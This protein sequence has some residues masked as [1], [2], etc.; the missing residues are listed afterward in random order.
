MLHKLVADIIRKHPLSNSS[1]KR[2]INEMVENIEESLC[3]YLKTCKFSFQLDES[4]L[5]TNQ[6]LLLSYVRFIKD[7][8][9]CKKLLFAKNL[10]TYQKEK[11]YLTEKVF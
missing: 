1:V 3:N 9:I 7:E 6:A 10:E 11:P 5:P 4:S 2:R 8:K